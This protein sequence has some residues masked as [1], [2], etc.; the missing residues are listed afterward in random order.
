MCK[1]LIEIIHFL[2][3]KYR[4]YNF[5]LY[6]GIGDAKH[7]KGTSKDPDMIKQF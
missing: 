4:S 5:S 7:P 2:S 1:T 3:G 6:P